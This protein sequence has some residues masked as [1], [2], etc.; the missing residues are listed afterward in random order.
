MEI[1]SRTQKSIHVPFSGVENCRI[2]GIALKAEEV[3]PAP[4]ALACQHVP[5][6]HDMR[7]TIS[8][9][10]STTVKGSLAGILRVA[11]I[12]GVHRL[13]VLQVLP[14]VRW[15]KHPSEQVPKRL[16]RFILREKRT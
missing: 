15:Q 7:M 12:D 10:R 13:E 2:E 4:R 3:V 9:K 5:H 11:R 16:P 6:S 1:L 14:H 8:I